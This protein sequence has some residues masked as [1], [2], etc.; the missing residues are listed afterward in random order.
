MILWRLSS[1]RLHRNVSPVRHD[2][3]KDAHAD[4]HRHGIDLP[5]E[6]LGDLDVVLEGQSGHARPIVLEV[7]ADSR[8]PLPTS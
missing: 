4:L 6:G 7:C 8:E 2:A 1:R 5:Y 3:I